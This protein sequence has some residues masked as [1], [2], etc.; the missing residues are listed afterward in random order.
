VTFTQQK[1]QYVDGH[2]VTN[3]RSSKRYGDCLPLNQQLT[4]GHSVTIPELWKV[5]TEMLTEMGASKYAQIVVAAAGI[6]ITATAMA[7]IIISQITGNPLPQA[8]DN[9]LYFL[10][11]GGGV[12]AGS[13]QGASHVLNAQKAQPQVMAETLQGVTTGST[14]PTT[15]NGNGAH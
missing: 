9:L 7:S 6:L 5:S 10:L 11:G 3:R 1:T 14:S 8:T 13:Q 12:L 2:T 15:T 4:G